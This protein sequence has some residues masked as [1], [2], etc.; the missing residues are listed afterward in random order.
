VDG[1][2]LLDVDSRFI[3]NAASRLTRLAMRG[4]G[5]TLPDADTHTERSPRQLLSPLQAALEVGMSKTWVW[6]RCKDG[7]LPHVVIGTRIYLRR[8]DLIRDGWLTA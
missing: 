8:A 1:R 7:T 4:A 6:E 5:A 2:W 3:L